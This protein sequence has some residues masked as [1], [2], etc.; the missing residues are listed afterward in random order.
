MKC[1]HCNKTLLQKVQNKV[2]RM[3]LAGPLT[4]DADTQTVQAL[5]FWCEEPVVLTAFFPAVQP[6]AGK[7]M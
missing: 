4:H 5:C 6:T 1:P 3:R 2:T 7:N